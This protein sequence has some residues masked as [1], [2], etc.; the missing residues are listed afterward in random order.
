[1]TKP[2]V[3]DLNPFRRLTNMFVCFVCLIQSGY[4]R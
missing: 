1:L 2:D 3:L 4:S